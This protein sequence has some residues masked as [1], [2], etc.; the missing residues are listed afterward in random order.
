MI[1][2]PRPRT[3]DGLSFEVAGILRAADQAN[4]ERFHLLGYSAGGASSLAFAAAHP[5]RLLSLAVAE[6]AWDGAQGL[7]DAEDAVWQEVG[8][9]ME[10]PEK[11]A[12]AAFNRQPPEACVRP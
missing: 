10:L 11:Q 3:D 1:A 2:T 12:L 7:S 8:R 5:E 6:P 4:F 9:I